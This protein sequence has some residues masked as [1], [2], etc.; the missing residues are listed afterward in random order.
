LLLALD[1]SGSMA[2]G[3]VAG[4]SL[5]PREASA[6]MALMTA[7]TDPQT[8]IVGFGAAMVPLATIAADA[9]GRCGRVVRRDR[10]GLQGGQGPPAA[11]GGKSL[12]SPA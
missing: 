4:S 11:P 8:H 6:T 7:A 12:P 1:V 9:A 2:M 10:A 3:R 5:T